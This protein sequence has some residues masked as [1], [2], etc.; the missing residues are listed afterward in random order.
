MAIIVKTYNAAKLLHD[1]TEAV[2]KKPHSKG[3]VDVWEHRASGR[4]GYLPEQYAGLAYFEPKI[5]S[6]TVLMFYLI[7][8]RE[9]VVDSYT[10]AVYHG[11][12]V[13]SL[14]AHFAT[15]MIGI[16]ATTEAAAGD[17]LGA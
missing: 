11:R 9:K 17:N 14:L 10:Y 2:K 15:Q 6:K 1:F 12:L 3:A 13:E 7:K 5:E 16:A 8:P 4:F